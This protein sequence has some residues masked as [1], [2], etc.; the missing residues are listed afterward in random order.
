VSL[1]SVVGGGPV[2]AMI[3]N[4]RCCRAIVRVVVMWLCGS[5]AGGVG[6]GVLCAGKEGS[7]TMVATR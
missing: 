1:S 3:A 4:V 6:V 5:G 2:L 7:M